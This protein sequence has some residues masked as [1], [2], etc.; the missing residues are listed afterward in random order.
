MIEENKNITVNDKNFAEI[1]R[2]F[3]KSQT[4]EIR[5]VREFINSH[6]LEIIV[7][8]VAIGILVGIFL[9]L[10]VA[11]LSVSTMVAG[12]AVLT[13]AAFLA[14]GLI[15]APIAA[16]FVDHPIS[17]WILAAIHSL[18]F[19][20]NVLDKLKTSTESNNPE[21]DVVAK[22]NLHR[23]ELEQGKNNNLDYGSFFK[24]CVVQSENNDNSNGITY[25]Q[26]SP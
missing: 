3:I 10:V 18:S 23:D 13:A 26:S 24:K 15:I 7:S 5:R 19:P 2:E 21:K 1:H 14:V 9:P 20:D 6:F 8:I 16:L 12:F 4:D 17:Q 25:C 22:Q 11:V